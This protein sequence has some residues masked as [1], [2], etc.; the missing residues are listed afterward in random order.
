MVQ[1]FIKG[2]AIC[3]SNITTIVIILQK[4]DHVMSTCSYMDEEI[5]DKIVNLD[6]DL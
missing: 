5:R 6:L 4:M 3:F 1:S 2:V